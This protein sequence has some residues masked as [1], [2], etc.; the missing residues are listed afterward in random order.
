[1]GVFSSIS[2]VSILRWILLNVI[3]NDEDD[4][5][6]STVSKFKDDT[7]WGVDTE[8]VKVMTSQQVRKMS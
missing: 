8:V 5:L 1:M 4:G 6:K 2:E 7:R 3:I